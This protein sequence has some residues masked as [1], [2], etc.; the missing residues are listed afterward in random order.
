M[1]ISAPGFRIGIEVDSISHF[2]GFSIVVQGIFCPFS[3]IKYFHRFI[4][5]TKSSESFS[6]EHEGYS[7]LLFDSIPQTSY[8]CILTKLSLSLESLS[9]ENLNSISIALN[10]F[11]NEAI[12]T[13][14]ELQRPFKNENADSISIVFPFTLLPKIIN[15]KK[16]N[17]SIDDFSPLQENMIRIQF[18]DL[19]TSVLGFS[20]L[21][22][23]ITYWIKRGNTRGTTIIDTIAFYSKE[24]S[25]TEPVSHPLSISE[26]QAKQLNALLPLPEPDMPEFVSSRKD[27]DTTISSLLKSAFGGRIGFSNMIYHIS[28]SSNAMELSVF[29][30]KIRLMEMSIESSMKLLKK[31][32]E[33]KTFEQIKKEMGLTDRDLEELMLITYRNEPTSRRTIGK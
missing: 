26:A 4:P 21:E 13:S 2:D 32:R 17:V 30:D 22:N 8:V 5:I 19:L 14:R 10:A 28:R 11:E 15:S 31:V 9:L 25:L 6:R 7:D 24:I 29:E 1:L 20:P 23:H 12:T 3:Q 33:L 18:S 27:T 16:E